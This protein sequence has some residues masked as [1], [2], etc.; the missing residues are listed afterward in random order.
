[1]PKIYYLLPTPFTFTL[2][3]P[4]QTLDSKLY[5]VWAMN[6]KNLLVQF[7]FKKQSNTFSL[8][9]FRILQLKADAFPSVD[10]DAKIKGH[11]SNNGKPETDLKENKSKKESKDGSSDEE[12]SESETE[13]EEGEEEEKQKK[14]KAKEKI[15]FRDRKV[16]S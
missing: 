10:A 6:S 11:H 8:N 1:M 13:G 5:I 4:T 7:T 2:S 14:K 16:N 3:I 12:S 9:R 15:G